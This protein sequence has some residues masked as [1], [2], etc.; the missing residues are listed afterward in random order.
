MT[1]E[2]R[3]CQNCGAELNGE[4][5]SSCGQRDKDI[6][7]PVKELASEFIDVLP[8]FDDRLL[9]SIKP[10]LFSPGFLTTEY[11]SGRRKRY[12]SPFKFYF[13]ISFVF[14]FVSASFVSDSKA[15]LRKGLFQTDSLKTIIN[16]DSSNISIRNTDSNVS[17]TLADTTKIKKLFGKKFIDG[18]KS[19]KN[20]PQMFFNKIKEHLPKIIFLLLPV[21][22]VLLKLVYIRSNILYIKH[23]IF[24]FYFHSFIF[25]ILLIDTISEMILPRSI[26]FYA[27]S[28]MLLIP[29]YLYVGLRNV[30]QQ[31]RWK[32]VVKL[33]LLS[34]SHLFVFV[35]TL[36]LLVVATIFLF[37]S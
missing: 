25:F 34:M 5:C 1:D 32:T 10:F 21:F 30:Y 12:I 17:F 18:F 11:L 37:F 23:L 15:N 29:V 22:A 16:N 36:S 2:K 33:L 3:F 27:N 7:V 6:H 13:F 8:S 31:S 26:Q 14:F 9:R 35:M 28:I 19:G 20:N 24:S 4:F